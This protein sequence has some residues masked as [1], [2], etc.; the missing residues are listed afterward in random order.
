MV[1]DPEWSASME[2]LSA[3]PVLYPPDGPTEM[4]SRPPL[5]RY[6]YQYGG[7]HESITKAEFTSWAH[8]KKATVT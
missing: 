2:G 6:L 5:I 1:V 3:L 4:F 8:F 7:M